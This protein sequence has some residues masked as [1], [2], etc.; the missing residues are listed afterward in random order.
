MNHYSSTKE[1]QRVR[2]SSS[3]RR[4]GIGMLALLLLAG[5][6]PTMAEPDSLSRELVNELDRSSQF[7]CPTGKIYLAHCFARQCVIFHHTVFLLR[8]HS[9]FK[10]NDDFL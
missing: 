8:S 2:D 3:A 4:L 6:V 9:C 7:L 1:V 5:T 10:S